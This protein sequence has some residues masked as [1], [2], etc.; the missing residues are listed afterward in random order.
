MPAPEFHETKMG[1]NFYNRDVPKFIKAVERIADALEKMAEQ[2][3]AAEKKKNISR[4]EILKLFH[5]ACPEDT[6][7]ED[8]ETK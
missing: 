5:Y 6:S 8:K 4:R 1:Y 3:E 7:A 2:N